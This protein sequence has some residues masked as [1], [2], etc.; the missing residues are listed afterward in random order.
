MPVPNDNKAIFI[1]PG[2]KASAKFFNAE[3]CKELTKFLKANLP[4][5]C[6]IEDTVE[7]YG[8]TPSS[9]EKIEE[10][11][12]RMEIGASTP[13]EFEIYEYPE[14][15]PEFANCF[16]L[17]ELSFLSYMKIIKPERKRDF[18]TAEA[19]DKFFTSKNIAYKVKGAIQL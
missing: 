6:K 2:N 18:I 16:R 13:L 19:L 5:V 3:G 17:I 11:R 7:L 14:V 10:Y 15:F 8:F 9:K 1:L 4:N 12:K